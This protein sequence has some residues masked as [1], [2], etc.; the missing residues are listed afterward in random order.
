MRYFVETDRQE[1]SDC[2]T[3]ARAS[4]GY[5][6]EPA[7]KRLGALGFGE[8]IPELIIRANDW[9]P[10]VRS[11]ASAAI[12][13]L[14]IPENAEFFIRALPNLFHLLNCERSNHRVLID[15]VVAFLVSAPGRNLLIDSL[16]DPDR[17]LRRF[18]FD[19]V[20]QHQLL[21]VEKVTFLAVKDKDVLIQAVGIKR[22]AELT[23]AQ[24]LSIFTRAKRHSYILVRVAALRLLLANGTVDSA[25][26]IA[27]ASALDPSGAIRAIAVSYLVSQNI[28]ASTLFVNALQDAHASPRQ[29]YA[30]VWGLVELDAREFLAVILRHS[31]SPYAIA[32]AAVLSAA[33]GWKIDGIQEMCET[34]LNDSAPIVIRTA[35]KCLRAMGKQFS[36]SFL[37]NWV[38][39]NRNL[40]VIRSAAVLATSSNKWE[41]LLFILRATGATA[42]AGSFSDSLLDWHRESNR[43]YIDP[44]QEQLL[45]LDK[46]LE[47]NEKRCRADELELL[48][49][50]LSPYFSANDIRPFY[51]LG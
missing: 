11:A 27:R 17:Y 5:L 22:L 32:R 34:R 50:V 7:V 15:A 43:R 46:A 37:L 31:D 3:R 39:G 26:D 44:N 20:L 23:D 42:Q 16:V 48:K 14:L 4:S 36:A 38:D 47:A 9:V 29:L 1:F 40:T 35:V 28:C 33:H 24:V 25:A 41:R 45:Q 19:L 13:K 8:A 21:T 10:A 51:D 30:A 6:R 18:C 12:I 49:F 2:L